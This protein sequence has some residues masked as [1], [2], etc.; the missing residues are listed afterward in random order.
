MCVANADI[1]AEIKKAG[2]CF[3]QVADGMGVN[4]STFSRWLRKEMSIDKKEQ[5]LRVIKGLVAQR[6]NL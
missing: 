1:R 3:W 2:V 5:I 4:D 6:G